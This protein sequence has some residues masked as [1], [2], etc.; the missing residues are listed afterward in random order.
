MLQTDEPRQHLSCEL[1]STSFIWY[2]NIRRMLFCFH[3]AH[4][5][6]YTLASS[7]YTNGSNETSQNKFIRKVFFYA[8]QID[9]N[10]QN[11]A[12]LL[13]QLIKMIPFLL[14]TQC[15][16]CY[17]YIRSVVKNSNNASKLKAQEHHNANHHWLFPFSYIYFKLRLLHIGGHF[18]LEE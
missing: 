10:A 5:Y 13:C 3:K 18:V 16:H 1:K 6:F 15:F 8:L 14:F 7:L 4:K 17:N 11:G 2:I 12:V 9:V